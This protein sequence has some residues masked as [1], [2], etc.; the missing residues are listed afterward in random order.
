M[1]GV[2]DVV[3]C[4]SVYVYVSAKTAA[5]AWGGGTRGSRNDVGEG[6]VSVSLRHVFEIF[7]D[8]IL[9]LTCPLPLCYE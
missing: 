9:Y 2:W 6:P 1:G 5:M 3:A 7:C 4:A 8:T